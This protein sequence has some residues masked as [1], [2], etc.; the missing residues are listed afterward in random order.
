MRKLLSIIFILILIFTPACSVAEPST[1]PVSVIITDFG[2]ITGNTTTTLSGII[3]GDGSLIDVIALD[4]VATNFLTG[5]GTWAVPTGTGEANYNEGARVYHDANQ[6]V[7]NITAT[8]LAFNSERY[9]TDTIHD[10]VTNN[11]RLTCETAGKYIIV[12][13]IRWTSS[14]LLYRIIY[15]GLNGATI[16]GLSQIDAVQTGTT[17][18]IVTTIYDLAV[19]D[20]VEVVAYQNSGAAKNVEVSPNYSTEFMMQRIG[21]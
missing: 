17:E 2:S 13:N 21:D 4:D 15:I 5:E 12:A 7:P 10:N 20:Y 11:S 16:I 6:S 8:T 18:M 1:P 3:T 14:A 19:T 9:D